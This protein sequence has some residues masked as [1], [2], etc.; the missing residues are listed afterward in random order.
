MGRVRKQFILDAEKIHRAQKILGVS[1]ET[2]AVN[3]ALDILIGN[4]EIS[5]LHRKIAGR[6]KIKNTD[7]SKF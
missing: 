2:E 3:T 7:Q 6:L 4:T 5:D 1:T